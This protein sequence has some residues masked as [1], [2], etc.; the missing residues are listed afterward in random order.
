M[1]KKK[2][3]IPLLANKKCMQET[4]IT[5]IY[6]GSNSS[7]SNHDRKWVFYD[8]IYIYI[9]IYTYVIYI[10]H[11]IYIIYILYILYISG[12]KHTNS[13][14]SQHYSLPSFYFCRPMLKKMIKLKCKVYHVINWLKKNLKTHFVWYLC[15]EIRSD[16]GTWSTGMVFSKEHFYGKR[17]QKICTKS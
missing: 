17:I 14:H 7:M 5:I 2:L 12:I 16:T 3:A 11:I 8:Y 15:E 1:F 6:S 13:H 9:Y 4:S 10:I